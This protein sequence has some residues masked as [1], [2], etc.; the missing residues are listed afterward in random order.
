MNEMGTYGFVESQVVNEQAISHIAKLMQKRVNRAK[1][2][3]W[4]LQYQSIL[5]W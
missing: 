2:L 4:I 5:F 1:H 3:L